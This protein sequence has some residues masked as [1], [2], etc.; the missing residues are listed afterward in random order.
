MLGKGNKGSHVCEKA[1]EYNVIIPTILEQDNETSDYLSISL[2]ISL[3]YLQE[4]TVTV[5]VESNLFAKTC[6]E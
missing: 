6:V 5:V 4:L 3:T 2:F 1:D